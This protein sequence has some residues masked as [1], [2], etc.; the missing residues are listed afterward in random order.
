MK[1]L[2]ADSDW[3]FLRQAREYLEPMGHLVVNES[4]PDAAARRA[5]NW[6]PDVVMVSA[7]LPA[8]SDG[9]LLAQLENI[10]PRPAIVLT[11]LLEKFADAWRAWQHGGDELIIK[12]VLHASELHVALLVAMKNIHTPRQ[13]KAAQPLAK[14]A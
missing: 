12:P 5:E 1:I 14:S 7:E 10:H 8:C 3:Q 9:S 6:K 13:R 11:A 4:D 2:I